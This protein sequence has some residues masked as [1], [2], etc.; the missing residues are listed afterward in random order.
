MNK[1]IGCDIYLN[2]VATFLMSL[3][4]NDESFLDQK[5]AIE[6]C[7][8]AIDLYCDIVQSTRFIKSVNIRGHPGAGKKICMLYATLY[9]I[10]MGINVITTSQMDKRVLQLGGKHWHNIFVFQMKK[11]SHLIVEPS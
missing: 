1:S 10:S 3:L 4:Q 7:Q 6:T 8:K 11:I 9:A 2:P 5:L